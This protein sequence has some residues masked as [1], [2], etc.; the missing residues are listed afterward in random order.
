MTLGTLT[1]WRGQAVR[2]RTDGNRPR[3]IIVFGDTWNFDVHLAE[4]DP[5]VALLFAA[6][7]QNKVPK[8]FA[9]C[10][11]QMAGKAAAQVVCGNQFHHVG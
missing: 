1:L 6:G 9:D 3:L 11:V 5:S 10:L 7:P 2:A 4:N 8:L